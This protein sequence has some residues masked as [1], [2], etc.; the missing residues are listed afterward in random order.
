MSGTTESETTGSAVEKNGTK[1][2]K[3]QVERTEQGLQAVRES[4][5]SSSVPCSLG[6]ARPF[7]LFSSC[8]TAKLDA[9]LGTI[10]Q[11]LVRSFFFFQ[12]FSASCFQDVT[13]LPCSCL[14]TK[15]TCPCLCSSLRIELYKRNVFYVLHKKHGL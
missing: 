10:A 5:F 7:P 3:R 14:Q 9:S 1:I 12:F 4:G 15:R 6:F 11:K 13:V 2:N 8:S